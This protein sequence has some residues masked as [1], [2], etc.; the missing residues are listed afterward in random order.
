MHMTRVTGGCGCDS[1]ASSTQMMSVADALACALAQVTRAPQTRTIPLVDAA[2]RT[3]ASPVMAPTAMP[4]FDNSAMDGFALRMADLDG[5]CCLPVAGTVAA[6]DAPRDLPHGAALRIFTGAPLPMG[7]DAVVMIEACVDKID[8]IH[9]NRPPAQGEN[10]R[11][12]GSDQ[13]A[14]QELLPAGTRIAAHHIGLLAANGVTHIDIARP[15]RVAVFSTGDELCSGPRAAGQIPDANRPMLL[16]LARL[17]GAEVSD[18]GILPDDA[19][20]TAAALRDACGHFDLIVSSGAVSMGGKDHIRAA[21]T[22]AGGTVEGW[23]VA[24]KPG[25]PV[26]FGTLGD[27]AFTGLPGNPFAVYVGFHMFVL[28][29]IARLLGAAPA[30]FAPVPAIAGFDWTR[31]PGRAEVFPVRLASYD[32]AGLPVLLRLGQSVSATLLPLS[33]ADGL[34]I[35]PPDAVHI[36]PGAPLFWRPFCNTGDLT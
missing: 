34:A 11:R 5:R 19:G 29:Q 10:I 32:R 6:G 18:L 2:G 21:V 22:A 12:A 17:A 24:L 15:P 16:A 33:G 31:K 1:A 28:P 36:E 7:A 3:T 14:G 26:M 8:K 9:I 23:R 35:V 20:A 25:K 13:A 4:F 27:A 30:A